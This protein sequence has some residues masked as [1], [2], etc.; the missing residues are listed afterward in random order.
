[1]YLEMTIANLASWMMYTQSMKKN[2]YPSGLLPIKRLKD[3]VAPQFLLVLATVLA[4]SN[5]TEVRG[6]R[7]PDGPSLIGHQDRPRPWASRSRASP[8]DRGAPGA[9]R[10]NL[11]V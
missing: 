8:S 4:A 9:A 6:R 1:V 10:E 5:A 11:Q 2:N 3:T 7:A